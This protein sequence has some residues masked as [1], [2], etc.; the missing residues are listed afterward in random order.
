MGTGPKVPLPPAIT[1]AEVHD[2][3]GKFSFLHRESIIYIQIYCGYTLECICIF[4]LNIYVCKWSGLH[5][6]S[7][8][9]DDWF[10][11]LTILK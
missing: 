8:D 5:S 4:Y 11:C 1:H 10:T 3:N 2:E 7:C 6:C 9:L